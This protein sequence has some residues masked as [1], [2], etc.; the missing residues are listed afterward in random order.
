MDI[1]ETVSSTVRGWT[2]EVTSKQHLFSCELRIFEIASINCQSSKIWNSEF[3]SPNV[4]FSYEILKIFQNKN[5]EIHLSYFLQEL[6]WLHKEIMVMYIYIVYI[7]VYT[8]IHSLYYFLKLLLF[9]WIVTSL[10]GHLNAGLL[11]RHITCGLYG[12]NVLHPS[13]ALFIASLNISQKPRD[14]NRQM[15]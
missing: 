15:L 2:P 6:V 3:F 1:F 13:S 10:W 8:Y 14:W 4:T 7:Y 5:S 9:F 12:K 11:V